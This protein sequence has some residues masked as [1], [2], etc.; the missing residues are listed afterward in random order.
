MLFRSEDLERF[1]QAG[2]SGVITKPVSLDRL[3]R[4]LR[5]VRVAASAVAPALSP[6]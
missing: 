4:G 1:V 6:F 2:A 3:C 5:D